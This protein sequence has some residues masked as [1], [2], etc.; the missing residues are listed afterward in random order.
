MKLKRRIPELEIVWRAFELRPHPV[1]TLDPNGDYLW[2]AWHG[3]VYPLAEQ[4]GMTMHMPPLQPRS[5]LAHEAAAWARSRGA[6][7]AMNAAI[8]RAFFERGKDI[9]DVH[10]LATLTPDGAGLERAL[11]EHEFLPVVLRDEER[12]AAIG[13]S[14]VPAFICGLRHAVGVQSADAL[15]HLVRAS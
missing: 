3:S 7:D 5:R 11:A 9:G 6:F 4:L 13:L 14:G 12:A 2:R 10:V 8:F 1:P 15:E